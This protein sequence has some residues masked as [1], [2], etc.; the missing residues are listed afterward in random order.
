MIYVHTAC[1]AYPAF[2]IS[3]RL[4]PRA[5]PLGFILLFALLIKQINSNK[6]E[7]G[8]LVF[9]VEVELQTVCIDVVQWNVQLSSYMLHNAAEAS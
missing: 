4:K 7:T 9:T 5:S 6:L 8:P 1:T 2:Y 3:L